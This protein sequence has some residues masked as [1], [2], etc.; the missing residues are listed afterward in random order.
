MHEA[1]LAAAVAGALRTAERTGGRFRLTVAGAHGDRAAFDAALRQ[2]LLAEL[3]GAGGTPI[4]IVHEPQERLCAACAATFDSADPDD[5][6]PTCGGPALPTVN[7]ER[8][9]LEWF[10]SAVPASASGVA[11]SGER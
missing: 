8:I 3:G 10:P 4:E 6:C 1:A 2:H 11:T 9:E 7:E 5:S